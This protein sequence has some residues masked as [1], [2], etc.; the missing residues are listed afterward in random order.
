MITSYARRIGHRGWVP[1]V[2]LP[3]GQMK[4]MRAGLGLPGAGAVLGTQTFAAWLETV[5]AR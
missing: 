5:P 3:G 1:S 4:G 2:S